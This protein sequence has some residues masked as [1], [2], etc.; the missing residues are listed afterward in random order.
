MYPK[1]QNG[2]ISTSGSSSPRNIPKNPNN[3]EKSELCR[4]FMEFGYCPYQKKCKFAHGS[5]ELKKN[6]TTNS[7]YKTK[8]C[9]AYFNEGNCRFGERCNFLHEKKVQGSK[10]SLEMEA[11]DNYREII[12]ER[13]NISRMYFTEGKWY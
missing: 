4:K 3:K 6:N 1:I 7:K 11:V 12:Y 5:H 10:N 9:G 8:E 13:R 2:S